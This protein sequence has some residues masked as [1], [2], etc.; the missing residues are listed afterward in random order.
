MTFTYKSSAVTLVEQPSEWPATASFGRR[1]WPGAPRRVGRA[2]IRQLPR[3]W[4]LQPQNPRLQPPIQGLLPPFGRQ[5]PSKCEKI[6][7]GNRA[8]VHEPLAAIVG[9]RS[10]GCGFSRLLT[11]KEKW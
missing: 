1:A 9:R 10:K 6:A 7:A 4:G 5:L 2:S 8:D 11:H 3:K